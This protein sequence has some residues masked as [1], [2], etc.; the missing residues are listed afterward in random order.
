VFEGAPLHHL[1][2]WLIEKYGDIAQAPWL[3][4]YGSSPILLDAGCG[5]AMSALALLEP[6]L[7]RSRYVGSDISTAV[8][9]A[10][11]RFAER[12]LQGAF[13]QVDL[14]QLPLPKNSIDIIFSEG[15]LHHT[16]DTC[17]ALTALVHHL[18]TGG[19]ILFYVYR[20]KGPVREFT[21]D[22]VRERL[23]SLTP[24]QAWEA[25]M[26][27]TKLGKALGDADCEI[28]VPET[29]DL[30]GFRRDASPCSACFIGAFVRHSTGPS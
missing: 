25:V 4:D 24:Q 19:R 21:D 10:R 5:A 11:A 8:D 17:A 28:E 2:K 14:Q 16:D 29:V 22:Y 23:Q 7:L 30:L 9:T 26:P 20:V 15:V 13:L 1:R 18:K 3:K 6:I 27:L 12:G